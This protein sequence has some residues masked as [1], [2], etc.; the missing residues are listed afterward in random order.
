MRILILGGTRFIGPTVVSQLLAAGHEVVLFHRGGQGARETKGATCIHGLRA[1]I[2]TYRE[3]FAR[4]K[5]DV[6]LDMLP[7]SGEDMGNVLEAVRGLTRRVVMISS[8]DVYRAYGLLIGLEQGALEPLPITEESAVRTVL[9]PYKQQ[10]EAYKSYEKL[11]AESR[12]MDDQDFDGTVLRLPMVYGPHDYQ[13]RFYPYLRAMLDAR[14]HIVMSEQ[15]ARWRN[16]IGYV[17][18]V[19]WGI[20]LAVTLPQ[21]AGTILNIAQE[22]HPLQREL[23]EAIA[24]ILGWHGAILEYPSDRLGGL[25]EETERF[26]Q[27]FIVDTTRIRQLLGYAEPV[28]NNQALF[29]TLEWELT[30]KH[31]LDE[32]I[33]AQ[34]EAEDKLIAELAAKPNDRA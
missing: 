10:N 30:I 14:P 12:L 20:Y 33:R 23:V 34:Y 1:N 19:G 18:N 28:D 26:E 13:H 11:T 8:Q 2:L 5:P 32:A 6:V 15:R 7:F 25:Q 29:R 3:Q 21:A 22:H 24:N 16:S 31:Q 17:D 9:Y 27:D 4:V